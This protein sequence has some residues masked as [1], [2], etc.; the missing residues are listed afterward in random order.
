MKFKRILQLIT[1]LAILIIFL[2]AALFALRPALS[3]GGSTSS[4]LSEASVE[5]ITQMDQVANSNPN[6]SVILTPTIPVT[7]YEASNDASFQKGALKELQGFDAL[8]G[9]LQTTMFDLQLLHDTFAWETFLALNLPTPPLWTTWKSDYEVFRQNGATPSKWGSPRTMPDLPSP[10]YFSCLK[11]YSDGQL[12]WDDPNTRILYKVEQ[13]ASGERL[14]DQNGNLVY[15]EILMN[16]NEFE[17]IVSNQLYNRDGQ[18]AYKVNVWFDFETNENGKIEAGAIE[19]KLAWKI[20]TDKDDPNRYYTS[21]AI[22]VSETG[23]EQKTVGLVGMHITQKANDTGM[24]WIW[25]TFE[26]VDN[27]AIE[28]EYKEASLKPSFYDPNC[29]EQDCPINT[30]P[31]LETDTNVIPRTQV[32]R[33][34]VTFPLSSTKTINEDKRALLN[35]QNSLWQYYQLIGTEWSERPTVPEAPPLPIPAKLTN[36]VIETYNQDDSCMNCHYDATVPNSLTT[37]QRADFTYLL[38]KA[39]W[40]NFLFNIEAESASSIINEELPDTCDNGAKTL[41][42]DGLLR[43]EFAKNKIT[44]SPNA[45]AV[46]TEMWWLITDGAD[47]YVIEAKNFKCINPPDAKTPSNLSVYK[48]IMNN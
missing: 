26:Q 13:P 43:N 28:D 38:G 1:I 39:Q 45:E 6:P 7:V 11:E 34:L 15:Y 22:I 35:S 10:D 14:W 47:N 8:L 37:T 19:L 18:L 41:P 25:A 16:Q 17:N 21:Q 27:V 24:K 33:T 12:K 36:T 9:D 44:L 29:N 20:I 31:P 46:K 2:G 3:I 4:N 23:C 42:E 32:T 30:L 5:T 40:T 48:P